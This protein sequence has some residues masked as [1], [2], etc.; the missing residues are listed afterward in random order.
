MGRSIAKIRII[1]EA[2]DVNEWVCKAGQGA[3]ASLMI[4]RSHAVERIS[5][6][7]LVAVVIRNIEMFRKTSNA[8]SS[9]SSPYTSVADVS[10]WA[11]VSCR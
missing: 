8:N 11:I 1:R 7:K 4:E 9:H 6:A 5:V 10:G 3:K 2:G